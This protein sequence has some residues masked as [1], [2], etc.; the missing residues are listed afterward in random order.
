MLPQEVR[1]LLNTNY[2]GYLCT[3]GEYPHITPIFFTYDQRSSI[4]FMSEFKSKKVRNI[5]RDSR[6]ALVVDVRD[7]SDPFNNEGVLISGFA[8]VYLPGESVMEDYDIVYTTYELFKSKYSK[9]VEFEEKGDVVVE[10]RI[11][12]VS[13]WKGTRFKSFRVSE[14]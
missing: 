9:F 4:H 14:D 5:L 6:V 1:E 13:Y 10:I 3:R 2:F 12:R 7:E 8:K 11:K